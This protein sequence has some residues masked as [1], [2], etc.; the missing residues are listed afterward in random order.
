MVAKSKHFDRSKL[1]AVFF[2]NVESEARF[3]HWHYGFEFGRHELHTSSRNEFDHWP[4]LWH[5]HHIKLQRLVVARQ[6][7]F[8]EPWRIRVVFSRIEFGR[9]R[10][11]KRLTVQP[12]PDWQAKVEDVGLTFHTIDDQPYWDESVCYEFTAAEVDIMEA[13]ANEVH[14]R[15]IEAAEAVI[16]NKWYSR[17]SIPQAA[18]PEIEASWERDDKSI[19][20]RFDFAWDGQG[21]P[22]MLEYNADTPTSLLEASVVQWSWL[23]ELAQEKD[24]FNSIHERLIEAWRSHPAMKVHFAAVADSEEDQQSALYLRDT[25]QQSGK[26]TESITIEDLGFDSKMGNFVDMNERTIEALFKLYPWEWLWGEDFSKHL[27]GRCQRFIEPVWKMLLSNKG[28]LPIL[29]DMFPNHPNLLPSFDS[30]Q[31]LGGNYVKKPKLS[32]EGANVQMVMCGNIIDQ[33]DGDYGAEGYVYQS[34]DLSQAFNDMHPVLGL[35]IVDNE[36]AGLGIREES[37]RIT[38]NASRFVPHWFV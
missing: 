23:Q 24:Q 37:R 10:I 14:A 25:C 16:K 20:G 38:T 22:K 27:S 32:R 15:C 35:W 13:A 36:A 5:K 9:R 28:L 12:R 30:P 11:M 8:G 1:D 29:W 34:L 21:P 4:P 17:L 26:D 19:Y 2:D 6:F 18:I 7:P 3:H 33:T 31:S